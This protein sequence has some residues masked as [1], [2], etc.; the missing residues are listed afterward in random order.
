[1]LEL[2]LTDAAQRYLVRAN[3]TLVGPLLVLSCLVI[4]PPGLRS[5]DPV[6]AIAYL[7]VALAMV[8]LTYVLAR[9]TAE[10]SRIVLGDGTYTVHGWGRPKRFAVPDVER[11]VT[12]D[13]MALG[14]TG[15]THHLVVVGHAR[16]LVLLVGRMWDREQLSQVALDLERRG[17][18]L[19]P[20]HQPVTP[21]QLRALDRRLVPWWQAHPVAL[22]LLVGLGVLLVGVA[23]FVVAVAALL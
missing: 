5:G 9:R 10:R 3:M 8:P 17:V 11:V 21:A 16:R 4:V 7:C 6:P 2:T 19:T 1:V 18:P 14:G 12:V 15:P 20:V 22:G 13:R 23:V